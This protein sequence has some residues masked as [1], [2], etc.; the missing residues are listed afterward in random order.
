M[1]E[2]QETKRSTREG[3]G[4][5]G[6]S[7]AEANARLKG[8]KP[9]QAVPAGPKGKEHPKKAA[10]DEN[11]HGVEGGVSGHCLNFPSGMLPPKLRHI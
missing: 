7:Q 6:D 10:K 8:A 2:H 4:A 9:G 1:E 5:E 11:I 3:D